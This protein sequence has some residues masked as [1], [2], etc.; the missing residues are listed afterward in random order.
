MLCCFLGSWGWPLHGGQVGLWISQW[1]WPPS[2]RE[3]AGAPG[4]TLFLCCTETCVG[5]LVKNVN[6][7]APCLFVKG[8]WFPEASLC[9]G[10]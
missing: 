6:G 8:I 10:R 7:A 3:E 4:P 9:C 5:A 1:F 2:L